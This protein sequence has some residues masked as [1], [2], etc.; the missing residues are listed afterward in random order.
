MHLRSCYR[1]KARSTQ[2]T[3][4]Q[5]LPIKLQRTDHVKGVGR[6]TPEEKLHLREQVTL[7]IPF[8]LCQEKGWS[9]MPDYRL[10]KAEPM[11]DSE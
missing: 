10:L 1:S 3:G 5:D 2:C 9:S 4:L 7:H 6:G 8:L 11:D